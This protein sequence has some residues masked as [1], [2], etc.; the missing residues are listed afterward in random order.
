[1]PAS[2][3]AGKQGALVRAW[4]PFP[5][6]YRQQSAAKLI[7]ASDPAAQVAPN[8]STHRTVY[9]ERRITQEQKPLVFEAEFSFVSS[10]YCPSLEDSAVRPLPENFDPQ[11]LGPREPHIRLSPQLKK[12][13]EE[14][15]RGQS[16]PLAR[17]LFVG[18]RY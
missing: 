10:A 3:L 1:M 18:E 4:L 11:H 2:T 5:Q 15:V 14:A 6:E 13:A 12:I 17:E 9:F 16:N 8:G 7:S